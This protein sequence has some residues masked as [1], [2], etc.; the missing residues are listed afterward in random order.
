LN[1]KIQWKQTPN[2]TKGRKGK[3]PVAI[4]SHQTAGQCPGSLTWL[5]N[6]KAQSSAHYLIYRDSTIYQL[7]KDE[8]TSWHAGIVN[9]PTW[10]LY[11][12]SNP[13]FYTIGIEHECYPAVGGDGNLT[14]IQYQAS[15]WLH[16]Q[17]IDKYNIPID[18]DHLIGH[19]QIDSK[20]RPN[21]PGKVFPW[22]RLI[23]D[24]REGVIINMIEDWQKKLGIDASNKL[25][26]L[27]LL[28]DPEQYK[29]KMGEKV[30][31]WLFFEMLKR[32]AVKIK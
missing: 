25:T 27:G 28:N 21:C 7:V 31:N 17:L 19:Y 16:K 30:D 15:L 13:N 3:K 12:G 24:L 32:I 20:N 11:D 23:S 18:R 26:E 6:P 10:S 8:D 9:K 5:C 4:V 29:D 22:D 1:F 2:Y 14:E